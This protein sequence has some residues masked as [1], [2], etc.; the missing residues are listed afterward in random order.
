VKRVVRAGRCYGG[1]ALGSTRAIPFE[2]EEWLGG[3]LTF[4]EADDAPAI[5]VTMPDPRCVMVNFDPDGGDR[6]PEVLKA[7]VR[8]NQNNA[9]IDATVTRTGHLAVGKRI[10]L[11]R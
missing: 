9:G 3:A 6:A 1:P 8:A 2:E 7:V 10:V 4:G 11:H 5:H